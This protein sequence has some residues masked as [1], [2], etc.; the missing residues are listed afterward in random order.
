M[1]FR[2]DMKNKQL[3]FM[4]SA[5]FWKFMLDFQVTTQRSNLCNLAYAPFETNGAGHLF[6]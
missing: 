1:L 6:H 5:M 3:C 4:I 2:A